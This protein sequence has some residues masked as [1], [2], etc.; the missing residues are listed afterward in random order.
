MVHFDRLKPCSPTTRI[1]QASRR[2]PQLSQSSSHQSSTHSPVGAGLELV[3]DV[4]EHWAP[5]A[6]RRQA[7][8]ESGPWVGQPS[9]EH[10]VAPTATTSSEVVTD[11]HHSQTQAISP[12]TP[13][14]H[15]SET[16][17]PP[18]QPNPPGRRYPQRDRTAPARLYGTVMY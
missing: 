13:A 6:D 10:P 8:P 4:V 1:P 11:S 5:T 2:R 14:P 9:V 16:P 18:P 3:D 12:T 15:G 17:R 7:Q